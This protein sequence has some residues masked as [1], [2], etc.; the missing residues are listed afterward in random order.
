MKKA[1]LCA[2]II[3]S[4]LIKVCP[5]AYA[6]PSVSAK[7]AIL[8]DAD[9]LDILYEKDANTRRAM[10]STTKI[11][12][13]LL[14]LESEECSTSFTVDPAAI[15]VE[16]TS[17]GLSEGDKVTLFDLAVGMLMLSGNDAANA[18]A[19]KIAGDKSKF[20]ELMNK[21]ASEIGMKNTNFVTP[22]GLDDEFHY[23]T[24]YDLALLGAEAIKNKVFLEISSKSR[25][26][27]S[28]GEPS[29]TRTFSNHNRLV[30]KLEGCIGIKT[31]FT[32]KAGRCLVSAVTK[33]SRTLICVTLSAPNDW[34]DHKSLYDFGFSLYK[35]AAPP[36]IEPIALPIVNSAKNSIPVSI[37]KSAAPLFIRS[38]EK[39]ECKVTLRPFE[40]AP[41]FKGQVVGSLCYCVGETIL[42][43]IPLIAEKS[44]HHLWEKE[45]REQKTP[46]EKLMDW[47]KG[48]FHK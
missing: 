43:E 12:T 46:F 1:L 22:S 23:S 5:A 6:A 33:N 37:S 21:R 14:C 39:I 30:R 16:G 48:L 31:G 41:I 24:A 7:S 19:I 36:K 15:K 25:Y 3:F 27:V 11:M 32:K 47:L 18:A 26:T 42:E 20:A 45:Q 44:A 13:T 40:Y 38:G 2:I 35:E 28:Y 34:Q 17:M 8:I 4:L 29:V 9:T 10:A